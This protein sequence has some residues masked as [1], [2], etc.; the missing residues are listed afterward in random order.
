M[1]DL[2]EKGLEVANSGKIGNTNKDISD[3]KQHKIVLVSPFFDNYGRTNVNYGV[4]R[5]LVISFLVF[6]VSTFFIFYFLFGE[7]YSES[8][9]NTIESSIMSVAWYGNWLINGVLTLL[10]NLSYYIIGIVQAVI[11]VVWKYIHVYLE[12]KDLDPMFTSIWN[13]LEKN[14]HIELSIPYFFEISEKEKIRMN[15]ILF[16]TFL[17]FCS[18]I[19]QYY[20]QRILFSARLTAYYVP[21]AFM[22]QFF[23][24]KKNLRADIYLL[25]N[26][27]HNR[28]HSSKALDYCAS[29]L[30]G[31][32]LDE[33]DIKYKIDNRYFSYYTRLTIYLEK[34]KKK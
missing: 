7:S 14:N 26:F 6:Y 4:Y 1:I 30:F 22:W 28:I 20:I 21:L 34:K 5:V 27:E 19:F 9:S 13:F 29:A 31:K 11:H 16:L 15:S 33:Y 17:F 8:L 25:P 3:D 24:R 10:S 32:N 23:Q 18:Y 12:V 2:L